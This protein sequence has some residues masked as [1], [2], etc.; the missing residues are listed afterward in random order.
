MENETTINDLNVNE[1]VEAEIKGGPKKIF[2]GGLSVTETAL[3]D[4]EPEGNV[5]GGRTDG[6]GSGGPVLNHN[7]TTANDEEAE[8]E[9]LDDLAVE[10]DAQVKG[11]PGGFGGLN[12]NHNETTVADDA[13]AGELDDLDVSDEAETAVKGGAVKV[14]KLL[15]VGY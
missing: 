13:D 11:G 8:T 4:L 10:D 6:P 15:G 14:G 2:I 3:P 1:T 12:L 7:E 9:A 5:M